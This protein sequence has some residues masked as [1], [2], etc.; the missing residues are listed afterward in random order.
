[1]P[2]P[3]NT[4][5]MTDRIPPADSRTRPGSGGSATPTSSSV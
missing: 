1:M 4:A 5:Y 2:R 3:N